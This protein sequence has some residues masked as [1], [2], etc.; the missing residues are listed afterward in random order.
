MIS[1]KN[2]FLFIHVPKTGGNSLQNI[3]RHY[4]E[5]E[6]I[7]PKEHQDGVERFELRNRNYEISKHSTLANYQLVLDPST[8]LSLFKFATIRNPWERM[9]SFYF[10]PNRGVD[11]WD[12]ED[13]IELIE[14]VQT[15]RHYVCL[16]DHC[17]SRLDMNLDFIIRFEH[18]END[19]KLVADK[20]DIRMDSLPKRNTSTRIH[21]S[22]YYDQELVS[23][24][25]KKFGEEIEFGKYKF[26]YS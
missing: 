24:V 6:I 11:D 7:H 2:N 10:S 18:L 1:L 9:I 13:F 3:L 22:R 21:Y 17:G 14:S 15:F 23:R 25:E 19:F 8:F 5:D 12:R 4:S 26:E 20:L 16:D